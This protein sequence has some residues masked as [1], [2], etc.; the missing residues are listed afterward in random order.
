MILSSDI[1]SNKLLN[2]INS[3][4]IFDLHTHLF[5]PKHEGYFLLGFK[6][7][8]N[9]HYLIA[10]LLTT[11]NIDAST[12]YSYN[13]EKKASLIWNELFEKRTPVSEACAGVLSIL[14]E[15]NIE[16]NNKSFL[17]ICDEYDNKIQSDKNILDLSKVSSLVMTNNPFDLDE[18]SLFNN[19]D[20][21]KKIYLSSLRLDDLILDYEEA[22]KK[23]KDQTSN[24]EKNTI[25]NYLE[26]CY[27][28]S[29]PVYAAVSLNLETFHTI[30]EETIWKDILVWLKNKNLPLSLM[31]GVKRAVNKDFG[32]AGDGIG[33]INLKELS[34]LCNLFPKNKF[35]VTCLSLND[36]HELTVLARKHPNLRI[37]GFWWFMNQPTI[38]KQILKMRIDMLGFSFI[39]QHSDARVSDQLI[40]KWNHFKKILHPILLEY[41]Q[42]LLDK[43]FPISENILQ[44][45]INNLLS[46]NAKNYLGIT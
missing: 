22:L 3:T 28:Q 45:D 4:Q 27:S 6:N 11:T 42:D 23:A 5:P 36:Q 13:D 33:N 40:Y 34:N 24:H 26:K 46:G 35:L 39:P 29:N 17:S 21:D 31:L 44:R 20:W 19:G 9:Y 8:L 12:F 10:E 7:L 16:I 43:N 1:I 14:K 25:V 37:F 2:I 30:F 15:L 32:L 41:Y 18:W 38:I